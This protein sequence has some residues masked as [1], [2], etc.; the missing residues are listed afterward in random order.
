MIGAEH[1]GDD[2][3]L[4][5]DDAAVEQR[6]HDG[7]AACRVRRPR[8]RAAPWSGELSHLSDR[9][10]RRRGDEVGDLDERVGAWEWGHGFWA[11]ARS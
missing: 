7:Q 1:Q 2:D 4:V 11:A 6:C 5:V 8:R 3:P 9:M 10:N